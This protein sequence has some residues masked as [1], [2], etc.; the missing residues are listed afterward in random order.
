MKTE[1][2]NRIRTK[3][4]LT[5]E[6]IAKVLGLSGKNAVSRI[7]VGARNPNKLA[8]AFLRLLYNLPS[9]KAQTLMG[10]IRKYME[11]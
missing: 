11:T 1:E 7:E 6:E 4:G 9:K 2:F 5:Q 8:A 10:L 3:L